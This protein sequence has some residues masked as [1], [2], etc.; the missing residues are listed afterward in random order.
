M[1]RLRPLQD[2]VTVT[3]DGRAVVADR[4]EPAA[5]A[6]VAEGYW[7]LARSPKFH[8]PRGPACLRG[9]CDGC[10]AR[11][12]GVP[13][14]MTCRTAAADG[15]SIETQNVVGSRETDLL[16]VTDWFFPGGMNPHELAAG[17]PG[18]E[19]ITKAIARRVTGVGKLPTSARPAADA[20][21]RSIDTLVVGAGPA[22]MAAAIA[23][24]DRGHAVEVVEDDLTWGGCLPLLL[25]Q[26]GS[27]PHWTAWKELA[28]RFAEAL[29][30]GVRLSPRTVAVGIYG[31][32]VLVVSQDPAMSPRVTVVTARTLVLAPGAHESVVAFEGND[33]PGVLGARAGCRLLEAGVAPGERVVLVSVEGGTPFGEIYARA[34][35]DAIFVKG[36]PLRV[37]GAIRAAEVAVETADGERRFACDAV[38]IDAP[39]APSYE[40]CA[41]AGA[42]VEHEDR[43][44]V[45][46]PGPHGA[47]RPGIYAIG[48]AVGAPLEPEALWA[49]AASLASACTG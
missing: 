37:R 39:L 18:L 45:V 24:S 49:Q 31:D 47:V 16:R 13:N 42:H 8:R 25:L 19:R 48:E 46:R 17:V 5:I 11:V 38:L 43:G 36:R 20:V 22:G 12:D 35:P 6:L 9:G 27:R 21:R 29:R 3:L 32:D 15:M 34:C 4:G 2:P 30:S 7:A 10:L 44:Y 14:V 33:V 23:L 28:R 40:L 1:P 26:E 41:Q